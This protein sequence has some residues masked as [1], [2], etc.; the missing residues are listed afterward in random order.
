[1]EWSRTYI[2]STAIPIGVAVSF[3]AR[4]YVLK[5]IDVLGKG[6]LQEGKVAAG[7]E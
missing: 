3:A 2:D 7:E 5:R 4:V 1:M 6:P